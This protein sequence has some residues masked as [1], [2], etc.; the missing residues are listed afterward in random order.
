MAESGKLGFEECGLQSKI[1][2]RIQRDIVQSQQ[3]RVSQ[4]AKHGPL[5]KEFR[6]AG[7]EKIRR[8]GHSGAPYRIM[9]R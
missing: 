5:R 1:G 3:K 8:Q 9:Y 7:G 4:G 6:V 2:P